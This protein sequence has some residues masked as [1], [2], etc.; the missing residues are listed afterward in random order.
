MQN[1]L[2]IVLR[3]KNVELPCSTYMNMPG[4]KE[5]THALLFGGQRSKFHEP[6]FS[7]NLRGQRSIGLGEEWKGG[8]CIFM[9][10]LRSEFKDERSLGFHSELWQDC[11]ISNPPHYDHIVISSVL[12][13]WVCSVL[14]KFVQQYICEFFSWMLSDLNAHVF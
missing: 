9:W 14:V 1:C 7:E 4:L 10:R 8:Y 5:S 6:C 13:T 11:W 12:S 3:E 2:V